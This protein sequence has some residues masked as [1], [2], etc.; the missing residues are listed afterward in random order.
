MLSSQAI[1]FRTGRRRGGDWAQRAAVWLCVV[2]SG[3]GATGNDV[4][5]YADD[6]TSPVVTGDHSGSVGERFEYSDFGSPLFLDAAGQPLPLPVTGNPPLFT[7][8]RYDAESQLYYYRTRYLDPRAGRFTS[9]DSVGIWKDE[10]NLGNGSAYVGNTPLCRR[11]WN[12]QGVN[13]FTECDTKTGTMRITNHNTRCT[14]PCTQKHEELHVQQH[15][16]CCQKFAAVYESKT[17]VK[18]KNAEMQKW[19]D[20]ITADKP[21]AECE[22]YKVSVACA[23]EMYKEKKCS[24]CPERKSGERKEISELRKCCAQI[25]LYQESSEELEKEFCG[26]KAKPSPCPFK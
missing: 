8:R 17:T 7:G 3:R 1:L 21:W 20:Y 9:R 19:N 6:L 24:E 26:Q 16:A 14:R 12:G 4:Y 10:S 23:K 15:G 18:E 22:A 25:S 5:F 13:A 2:S 11:D